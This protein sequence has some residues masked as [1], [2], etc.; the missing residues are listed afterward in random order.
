MSVVPLITGADLLEFTW[1]VRGLGWSPEGKPIYDP[2]ACSTRHGLAVK[3]YTSEGIVGEY[4]GVGD[5]RAMADIV[6]RLLG[7]NALE[8]EKI[9]NDLGIYTA[10][11]QHG[12]RAFLD[13]L[14]WDIAGKVAGLPVYALLGGYRRTLPAYAA[15][16]DGATEGTL[17][18]VESFADYAEQC[19]ELGVQGFKIHPYP[20]HDV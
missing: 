17:S 19:L 11:Q 14:L 2:T 8:R 3:L 20:W 15:T 18:S 13:I 10:Q 4:V 16:I 5:A 7:A 9:Y 6:R 12:L 1:D